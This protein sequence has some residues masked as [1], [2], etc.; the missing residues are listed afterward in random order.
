MK[1]TPLIIAGIVVVTLLVAVVFYS[2]CTLQRA[3][4]MTGVVVSSGDATVTAHDQM[5]ASD[6]LLVD[7]VTAPDASWIVAYRVGM[8]GMPGALLGYAPIPAGTSRNVVIPID[9]SIRLTT[10]AI[11]SVNADRGVRGRFEF[12]MNRFEASTDKPY[13]VAGRAVQTTITVAFTENGDTFEFP[14]AQP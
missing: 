13:Y 2:A 3:T 6:S 7:S 4:V 5:G 11:I 10:E 1:R 8:E 9:T 12:D 14:P